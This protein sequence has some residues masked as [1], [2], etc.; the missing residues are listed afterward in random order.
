LAR[1][2]GW[3]AIKLIF[4]AITNRDGLVFGRATKASAGAST[5]TEEIFFKMFTFSDNTD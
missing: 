5:E 4:C 2:R 1:S 3:F